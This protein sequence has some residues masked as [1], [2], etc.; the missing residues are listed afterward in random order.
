MP[1]AA[2]FFLTPLPA[3]SLFDLPLYCAVCFDQFRAILCSTLHKKCL[4]MKPLA[5]FAFS[6]RNSKLLFRKS[7]QKFPSGIF[8][9]FLCFFVCDELYGNLEPLSHALSVKKFKS[10]SRRTQKSKPRAILWENNFKSPALFVDY[11]TCG[12]KEKSQ[13]FIPSFMTSCRDV[14]EFYEWWS[15]SGHFRM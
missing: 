8:L 9:K 2:N 5:A 14:R 11:I 15:S 1:A 10:A 4:H 13:A 3:F 12:W 6:R 7:E